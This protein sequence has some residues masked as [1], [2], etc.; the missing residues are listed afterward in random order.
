MTFYVNIVRKQG[1]TTS[2]LLGDLKKILEQYQIMNTLGQEFKVYRTKLWA[3]VVQKSLPEQ[4]KA[5]HKY[6]GDVSLTH[7]HSM[8][9]Q[10]KHLI[11]T[12]WRQ[13]RQERIDSLRRYYES[14]LHNPEVLCYDV[15][16][17]YREQHLPQAKK[18][19]VSLSL[20]MPSTSITAFLKEIAPIVKRYQRKGKIKTGW[21]PPGSL[22]HTEVADRYW[23]KL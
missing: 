9:E 10:A 1:A 15:P 22:N 17:V 8:K 14:L 6:L 3:S 19:E 2:I 23:N 12:E 20:T 5:K 4:E 16:S 21:V 7:F 11:W 13:R 18:R